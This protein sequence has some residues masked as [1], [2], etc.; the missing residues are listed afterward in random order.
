MADDKF[1]PLDPANIVPTRDALHAYSAVIGS[2]AASC[3]RRRKHWWHA[4]LRPS[5]FGLRTGPIYGATDFELEVDL[6]NSQLRLTSCLTSLTERL[7]GQSSAELSDIIKRTLRP[8]GIDER[9]GPAD[10]D[11]SAEGVSRLFVGGGESP[12]SRLRFRLG[13][14]RG[15]PRR[16]ARRKKSDPGVAAPF[17]TSR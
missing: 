13:C 4:S 1:P 15:F 14:A 17:S 3:R 2:W 7:C 9:F 16:Y 8:L 11:V 6:A 5:V 12:A 10:D